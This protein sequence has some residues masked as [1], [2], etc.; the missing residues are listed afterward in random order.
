MNI[1]ARRRRAFPIEAIPVT[2]HQS[3]PNERFLLVTDSFLPSTGDSMADAAQKVVA[4][5]GQ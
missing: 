1:I 5:V 2:L 4:A 3:D